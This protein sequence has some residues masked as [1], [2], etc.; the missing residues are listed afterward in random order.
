[1]YV[2]RKISEKR[3]EFVFI[4]LWDSMDGIRKFAGQEVEKAVYYPKDR[5]FLLELEPKVAHYE[6]MVKP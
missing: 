5:E 4:S 2:L 6:V 3:A 1:V